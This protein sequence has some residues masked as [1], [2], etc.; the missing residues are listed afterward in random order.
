MF[1]LEQKLHPTSATVS[2]AVKI[3]LCASLHGEYLI[4]DART[5]QA[6]EFVAFFKKSCV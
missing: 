5:N 4:L 2:S 6:L 3:A 1:W